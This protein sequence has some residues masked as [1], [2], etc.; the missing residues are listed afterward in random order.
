MYQ[1]SVSLTQQTYTYTKV[2]NQ[3]LIPTSQY[4]SN[5][6]MVWLNI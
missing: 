2:T 4:N 6:F 3:L 1:A 5:I